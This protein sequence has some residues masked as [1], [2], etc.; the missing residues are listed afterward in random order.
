MSEA[1]LGFN[2]K[3]IYHEE[4]DEF[5][6]TGV[7]QILNSNQELNKKRIDKKM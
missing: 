2:L 1:S 3:C 6:Q 7:K 4:E 5:I